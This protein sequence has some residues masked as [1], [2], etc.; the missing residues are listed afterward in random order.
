MQNNLFPLYESELGERT[1][2][3]LLLDRKS[4]FKS[5]F[6][7]VDLFAGIGGFHYGVEA[8]AQKFGKGINTL[9]VSEIEPNSQ[10]T[11][12]INHKVE[13]RGD[14]N[15]IELS[16][17]SSNA[18]IVTAG[19]PCQPFS[20]SGKKRGLS[21]PRGQFYFRIEEI[22]KHFKAKSF[23]LE[24][25]PG[26]KSNGG[27]KYRAELSHKPAVIGQS[28]HFLE[29][30]LLNLKDYEV[31]WVEV[32]SSDFGSPQVRRRVYIIGIHRDYTQN[33]NF[34]F[35]A[36][37]KNNFMSIVDEVIQPKLELSQNQ[38]DNL[39]S[40]MKNPPSYKNGMR[41][42]GKAYLCKGGNVGQGYHAYGLVPTLTKVWARFLPI[43]FPSSEENVPD[44]NLK[45]FN[46]GP[47]Y[48]HG[49]FRKVSV[50]EALL[51]Q[52][53]PKDFIPNENDGLAYEQAG[54]AVN[55][56]V[57]EKLSE[58]IFGHINQ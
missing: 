52:G 11:Y 10:K 49:Y 51:L 36:T 40:F 48:G 3:Y 50:R 34:H 26:I 55:A 41:R 37:P 20:N 23:I 57:V 12:K 35:G 38:E 4:E 44:V 21:D 28:M 2:P 17:Y 9:L 15:G 6:N 13:V 53:F 16:D 29:E 27:G 42:V 46:P 30:N 25:V 1:N 56:R 54:N 19:F 31:K 58:F 39:R 8:A 5:K 22:I 33:L 14:I 47:N 24:N 7:L 32:D 45:T 18:D 43:Y